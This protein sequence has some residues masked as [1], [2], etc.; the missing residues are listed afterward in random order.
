MVTL[1]NTTHPTLACEKNS[2]EGI[3]DSIVSRFAGELDIS[4]VDRLLQ[5]TY[6]YEAG[7]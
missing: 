5:I 3:A 7:N 6:T 2:R 1:C 4:E